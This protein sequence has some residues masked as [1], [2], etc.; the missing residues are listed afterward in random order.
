MVLL[1]K[2]LKKS[3]KMFQNLNKTMNIMRREKKSMKN[4]LMELQELKN[5]MS[6]M[7]SSL[8]EFQNKLN[9]T[10]ANNT[11]IEDREIKTI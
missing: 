10:E 11:E 1:V 3:I 7:K 9:I 4:Y 8:D 6:E 5:T 2:D